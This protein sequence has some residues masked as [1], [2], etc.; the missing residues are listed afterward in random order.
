[1]DSW[2]LERLFASSKARESTAVSSIGSGRHQC[3]YAS[4]LAS[5]CACWKFMG[6]ELCIWD[7][8]CWLLPAALVSADSTS[9]NATSYP[10]HCCQHLPCQAEVTSAAP[11]QISCP[12]P[13]PPYTPNSCFSQLSEQSHLFVLIRH[14]ALLCTDIPLL[15]AQVKPWER[16]RELWSA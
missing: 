13:C 15:G 4:V 10:N 1:M 16:R 7:N 8:S 2:V 6:E 9:V 12:H 3:F 14:L 11:S 5:C